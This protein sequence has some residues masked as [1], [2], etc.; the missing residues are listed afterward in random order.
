MPG[1][2]RRTAGQA[3]Q[4]GAQAAEVGMVGHGGGRIG[5]QL[6]REVRVGGI[7][8]HAQEQREGDQGLIAEQVDVEQLGAARRIGE[9][10]ARAGGAGRDRIVEALPVEPLV[11]ASV[12][13]AVEPAV[14]GP[15]HFERRE[16]VRIG[17]GAQQDHR[18]RGG[19]LHLDPHGLD[20]GALDVD[21]KHPVGVGPAQHGG[22]Q[23]DALFGRGLR[24]GAQRGHGIAGRRLPGGA[25]GQQAG[26][27]RHRRTRQEG[28][29]RGKG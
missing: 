8:R 27:E 13:L 20:P 15:R 1:G 9:H 17:A 23:G 7:V 16:V 19:V 10:H 22:A 18:P 24:A 11:Q 14:Y 28:G 5:E 4:R 12:G 26:D 3:L 29:K 2:V 21:A 25:A 6:A